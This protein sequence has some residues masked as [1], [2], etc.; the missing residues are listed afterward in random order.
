MWEAREHNEAGTTT[1]GGCV[2]A[3]AG[4][5]RRDRPSP[6]GCA[7]QRPAAF[8]QEVKKCEAVAFSIRAVGSITGVPVENPHGWRMMATSGRI[9]RS[10]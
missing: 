6:T 8:L 3:E 5:C 1:S 2:S 9:S 10:G 7:D 4:D